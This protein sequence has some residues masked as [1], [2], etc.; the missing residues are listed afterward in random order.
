MGGSDF[1]K[2]ANRLV[3]TAGEGRRPNRFELEISKCVGGGG[4]ARSCQDGKCDVL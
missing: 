1:P 4:E 2:S 3:V